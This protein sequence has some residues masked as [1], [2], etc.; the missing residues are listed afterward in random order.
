[1]S[2][3]RE[4]GN[5]LKI[6][7]SFCN[8]CGCN[9]VN[10]ACI[11]DLSL[12]ES[13]ALTE[14]LKTK[15]TKIKELESEISVSENEL[16]RPMIHFMRTASMMDYFWIYLLATAI[17]AQVCFI[18][19]VANGIRSAF[20]WPVL[21]DCFYAGIPIGIFVFGF[22]FSIRRSRAVNIGYAE[23]AEKQREDRAELRKKCRELKTRLDACKAEL[24]DLDYFIPEK[25]KD[26]HSMTKI[27]QLLQ[28]G[29]AKNLK[30]AVQILI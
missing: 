16:S 3:C 23:F 28:A 11:P 7:A 24:E 6:G 21:R 14:K 19:W 20:P 5:E 29:K 12:E 30:E 2:I 13:I 26:A 22:I 25:L 4:C 8:K 27:R 17:V 10:T 9:I 15:Y 1:M 18:L